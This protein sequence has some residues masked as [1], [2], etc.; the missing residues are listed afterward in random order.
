MFLA[1]RSADGTGRYTA[2][3]QAD[4]PGRLRWGVIKIGNRASRENV[5]DAGLLVGHIGPLTIP[6]GRSQ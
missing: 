1:L 4:G 2:V 6:K 3:E 5:N